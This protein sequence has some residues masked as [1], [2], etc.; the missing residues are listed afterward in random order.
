MRTHGPKPQVPLSRQS[1]CHLCPLGGRATTW[2]SRS[3]PAALR[4]PAACA[5][6]MLLALRTSRETSGRSSD[7][8]RYQPG[9]GFHAI[10][11][12][13]N[14]RAHTRPGFTAEDL[15]TS[16]LENALPNGRARATSAPHKYVYLQVCY[17]SYGGRRR[18]NPDQVAS[19]FVFQGRAF[20]PC[21]RT[22]FFSPPGKKRRHMR[23][24]LAWERVGQGRLL[25]A[26]E[27]TC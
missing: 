6:L 7:T 21:Q 18:R 2:I 1:R 16:R 23:D 27:G 10:H 17:T 3:R 13:V 25:A 4:A 11:A 19:C 20:V 26:E 9:A 5:A 22:G 15:N 24:S 12:V 14:R 8:P